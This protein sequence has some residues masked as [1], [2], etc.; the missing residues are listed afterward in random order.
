[1]ALL[2]PRYPVEMVVGCLYLFDCCSN[3]KLNQVT[4]FVA[5]HV[6]TCEIKKG[7][8]FNWRKDIAQF[9]C[10]MKLQSEMKSTLKV[11]NPRV[12]IC[13][14]DMQFVIYECHR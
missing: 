10:S 6:G 1:M 2:N 11:H 14:S 5:L 13:I 9:D 4:L 12:I 7:F 8:N 3:H